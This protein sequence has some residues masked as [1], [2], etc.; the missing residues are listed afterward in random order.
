MSGNFTKRRVDNHVPQLS[1][2]DQAQLSRGGHQCGVIE[3]VNQFMLSF[4]E[5]GLALRDS[6][7]LQVIR[8]TIIPTSAQP[9]D[10]DEKQFLGEHDSTNRN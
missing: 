9:G 10:R 2:S 1:A 6:E 7:G 3:M 4:I 5:F 8:T